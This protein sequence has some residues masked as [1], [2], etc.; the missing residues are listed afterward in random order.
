MESTG[1]RV[2]KK[3]LEEDSAT[4]KRM[5][6]KCVDIALRHSHCRRHKHE[7]KEGQTTSTGSG[8]NRASHTSRRILKA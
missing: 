8:C 6:R 4:N 3:K 5:N 2:W 1:K 7:Q